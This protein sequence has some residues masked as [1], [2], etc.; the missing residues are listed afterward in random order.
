MDHSMDHQVMTE[1]I[2]D[3]KSL[4]RDDFSCPLFWVSPF[5]TRRN[6]F[7]LSMEKKE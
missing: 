5:F 6:F 1:F 4:G 7:V 3:K 2:E